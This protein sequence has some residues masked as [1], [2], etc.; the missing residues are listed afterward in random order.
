MGSVPASQSVIATSNTPVTSDIP[1]TSFTCLGRAN[2]AHFADPYDCGMFYQCD[3][4]V[5]LHKSC[6]PGL[7]FNKTEQVCVHELDANCFV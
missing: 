5:A 7:H 1:V 4:G 3:N 6:G 2:G